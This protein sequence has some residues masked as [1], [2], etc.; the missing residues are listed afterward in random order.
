MEAIMK[1]FE[2]LEKRE[3]RRKEA[4]ARIEHRKSQ[5]KPHQTKVDVSSKFSICLIWNRFYFDLLTIVGDFKIVDKIADF[6]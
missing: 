1:A 2:K 6:K 4:L 3:E 5:D